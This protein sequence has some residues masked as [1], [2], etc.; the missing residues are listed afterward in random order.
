MNVASD[1]KVLVDSVILVETS[2]PPG[3]VQV[4]P[5]GKQPPELVQYSVGGQPPGPDPQHVYVRGMHWPGRY[6]L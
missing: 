3:P 4:F 2:T 1:S 5:S 6:R